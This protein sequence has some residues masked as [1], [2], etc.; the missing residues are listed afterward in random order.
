M[1]LE[2]GQILTQI[3]AFLIM[4]WILKRFAW[5]P[6]LQH[7]E[8]RRQ[9]IISEFSLAESK[10]READEQ[11]KAYQDKINAI[12]KEKRRIIQEA[13]RDGQQ[14]SQEIQESAH[15]EAK[16][17]VQ[18]AHDEALKEVD[19]AKI[20]LKNEMVALAMSAAEKVVGNSLNKEAQEKF[21]KEFVDQAS[22]K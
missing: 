1:K 5:K 20:Q 8:D 22:F 2:I 6:M 11:A 16:R 10:Q 17:V 3:L 7:L 15:A 18:N 21:V 14:I 9:K 13:I 19:T 4:L 12:E